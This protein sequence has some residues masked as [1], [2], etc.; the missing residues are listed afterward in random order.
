M[1]V[2][3]GFIYLWYDRK[4][5]KYYVGRHWG[6]IDDGYICSSNNMRHNY[7]NRPSDFKRRIISK[8]DSKEA[9]VLE[10]QRYLDMIKTEEIGSRYY[11]V[12][13]KSTTP[14]T[15]GYK[16]T[17]ETKSKMSESQIGKKHTEETKLKISSSVKLNPMSAEDREKQKDAVRSHNETRNYS[18]PLFINKMSN[19]AKNRSEETKAKISMNSKRLHEEG[20]IGMKGRKHSAETIEKMKQAAMMRHNSNK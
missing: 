16:H 18:D 17:A 2:K 1:T 7:R 14:T 9:L 13:L 12:S 4:H 5:K 6:T 15:R 3:Y 10:E 20:R 19:A 11:N 8:V